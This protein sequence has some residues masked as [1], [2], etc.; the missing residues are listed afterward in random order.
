[1]QL[2]LCAVSEKQVRG[3]TLVWVSG[4]S[5]RPW[6][7]HLFTVLEAENQSWYLYPYQ[8]VMPLRLLASLQ[9]I[10][11]LK[12]QVLDSLISDPRFLSLAYLAFEKQVRGQGS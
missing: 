5:S 7:T 3:D 12:Q 8:D 4:V 9:P 2:L 10:D 6:S 1:M 11:T